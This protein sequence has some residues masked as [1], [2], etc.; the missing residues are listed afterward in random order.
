MTHVKF[1]LPADDLK[2]ASAFYKDVFGWSMMDLPF[3]YVVLD[4]DGKPV[5]PMA[6]SGGISPRTDFVKAP[7]LIITVSSIDETAQKIK[8]AGGETLNDKQQVGDFGFSMYI[9]DTEG[10]VMCLWEEIKK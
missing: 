8:D 7:V 9:K 10:S 1:E 5:N 4:T 3:N 6:S 2:R